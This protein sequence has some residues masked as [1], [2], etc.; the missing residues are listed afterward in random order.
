MRLFKI[1]EKSHA[2]AQFFLHSVAL[3][4]V[5][6]RLILQLFEALL[7]VALFRREPG[8]TLLPLLGLTGKLFDQVADFRLVFWAQIGKLSLVFQSD[9]LRSQCFLSW[10]KSGRF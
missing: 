7:K 8:F 4:L 5:A 6:L 2:L 9:H 1:F 10:D 3:F